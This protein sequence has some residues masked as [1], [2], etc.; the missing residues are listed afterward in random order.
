MGVVV[1][2]EGV[3]GGVS[4]YPVLSPSLDGD[5]PGTH[6]SRGQASGRTLSLKIGLS[7]RR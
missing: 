4:D 6:A 3:C 7:A 5:A 1:L 2:D